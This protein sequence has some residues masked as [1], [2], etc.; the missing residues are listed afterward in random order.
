MA[1]SIENPAAKDYSSGIQAGEGMIGKTLDH[2][3]IEAKLGEGGMGVVYKARDT[4]LD[5][6]VAVEVLPPEKVADPER[7]RRF[8]QESKAASALNHP[9][10]IIIYDIDIA[11][12]VNFIAMEYVAGK[13]LDW[14]GDDLPDLTRRGHHGCSPESCSTLRCPCTPA[15]GSGQPARCS[16]RTGWLSS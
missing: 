8:V 15:P 6:F 2:Y 5:R 7:K 3:W 9:N 4:H 16:S 10:I 1:G 14:R 12:S 11:N 13:T